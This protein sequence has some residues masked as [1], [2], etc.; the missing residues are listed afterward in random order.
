MELNI[1]YDSYD[2]YS[3]SEGVHA[4]DHIC[5][6]NKAYVQQSKS[7][8]DCLYIEMDFAQSDPQARLIAK[9]S[10]GREKWHPSGMYYIGLEN[11]YTAKNLKQL[12]TA[13]ADSNGGVQCITRNTNGLVDFDEQKLIG[14]EVGVNY[15]KF[16][17]DF[18]GGEIGFVTKPNYFKSTDKV[19]FEANV[20]EPKYLNGNSPAA[21][22]NTSGDTG[23]NQIDGD[24]NS[25]PFV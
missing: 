3:E 24:E 1:N 12:A 17:T 2:S 13:I 10:E 20:Q 4:G 23:F 25:L 5:V 11:D 14:R 9:K 22:N 8:K 15:R 7:G 18:G 21:S 16:E 6:I 19:D